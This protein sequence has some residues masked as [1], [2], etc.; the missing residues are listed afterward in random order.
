MSE[1]ARL[2]LQESPF[3]QGPLPAKRTVHA[4]P[5]TEKKDSTMH[6][7]AQLEQHQSTWFL[8]LKSIVSDLVQRKPVDARSP[9]LD[10]LSPLLSY[11]K[12]LKYKSKA[13]AAPSTDTH[14]VQH[15][16]YLLSMPPLTKTHQYS[17]I[18]NENRRL[19]R[20]LNEMKVA[21]VGLESLNQALLGDRKLLLN[22]VQYI[23][24]QKAVAPAVKVSN[25]TH[26]A[27]QAVD[28]SSKHENEV[29]ALKRE[30]KSALSLLQSLE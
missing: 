16:E 23:R 13:P 30:L 10:A 14:H 12:K 29:E 25:G 21:M 19:K 28:N 15:V 17:A 4:V 2:F 1:K 24:Q 18:M 27:T 9:F 6:L 22:R 5:S 11:M 3:Y 20:E 7:A 26:K 8:Q